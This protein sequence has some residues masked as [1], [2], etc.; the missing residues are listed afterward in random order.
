IS[1]DSNSDDGDNNNYNT[2]FILYLWCLVTSLTA[3]LYACGINF[4]YNSVY[5]IGDNIKIFYRKCRRRVIHFNTMRILKQ[6]NKGI[7]S[8]VDDGTA[9]MDSGAQESVTGFRN[10]LVNI[11]TFAG[12]DISGIHPNTTHCN[13]RGDLLINKK[14]GISKVLYAPGI[15]ARLISLAQIYD[16]GLETAVRRNGNGTVTGI[17]V[18]NPDNQKVLAH[19]YREDNLF[20]CKCMSAAVNKPASTSSSQASKVNTVTADSEKIGGEY[21]LKAGMVVKSQ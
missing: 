4:I 10:D 17:D 18:V 14:L 20:K 21:G 2:N 13:E 12:V 3:I 9:T 5:K 19:F 11:A 1:T 6:V 8:F 15:Q 7:Q 16:A